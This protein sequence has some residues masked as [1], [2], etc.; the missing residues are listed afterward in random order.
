MRIAPARRTTGIAARR[1]RR[2][3]VMHLLRDN[4]RFCDN[5]AAMLADECL[6]LLAT[7]RVTG[8]ANGLCFRQFRSEHS[9]LLAS[10]VFLVMNALLP[11]HDFMTIDAP[12][13]RELK[14]LQLPFQR[15]VFGQSKTSILPQFRMAYRTLVINT[16]FHPIL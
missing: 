13:R 12:I 5:V 10:L 4:H 14:N 15:M 6:Q 16:F 7:F 9:A 2:A 3:A 1:A 8:L 11:H